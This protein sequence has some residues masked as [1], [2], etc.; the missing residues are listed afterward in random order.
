MRPL[1]NI[2][3]LILRK[4][5]TSR[6][7]ASTPWA[8]R[9]RRLCST[10]WCTKCPTI[11]SAR[12]DSDIISRWKY[13]FYFNSEKFIFQGG[14]DRTRGYVIG[15]KV[16]AVF[17]FLHLYFKCCFLY[18]LNKKLALSIVLRFFLLLILHLL[19]YVKFI[20]RDFICFKQMFS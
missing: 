2:N 11:D 9:P 13:L 6:S 14:F 4:W 10:A 20:F 15:K 18:Y 8:H 1:A 12:P 3:V 19:K 16:I 5:T 17:D 7:L